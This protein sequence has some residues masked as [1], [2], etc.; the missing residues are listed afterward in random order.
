MANTK[1]GPREYKTLAINNTVIIDPTKYPSKPDG[2]VMEAADFSELSYF[3][4]Y[5]F[6]P[7]SMY[8][9]FST[10]NIGRGGHM[11]SRSKMVTVISGMVYYCLVD[12]R[13]GEEQGK[14]CEFFLGEGEK[15]MG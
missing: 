15:S 9:I 6:D 7:R 1:T 8:T 5:K 4:G 3:L 10:K 11:E 13:P 14:V 2:W 12:M